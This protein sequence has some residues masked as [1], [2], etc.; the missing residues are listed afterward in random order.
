MLVAVVMLFVVGAMAAL[1]ID[2][3]TIYTARSEAQLAADGAALAGART[4]ANSGM[5]SKPTDALLT[6]NAEILASTVAT[7]VARSNT[8]GGRLLAAGEVIVTFPNAGSPGFGTNPQVT[9]AVKETNV[10]TFFARIWGRTQ[11]TVGTSATAEAYNPS[12]ANALGVANPPPVAPVCVK[13]WLLPNLDPTTGGT[14]TIFTPATGAITNTGLLGYNTLAVASR[15]HLSCGAPGTA[16]ITDCALPL[17][18]P[19]AWQYYPGD[20]GPASFPPPT[21]ALPTCVPALTFPYEESIAGCIQRPI[22][23]NSQVSIDT[24]VYNARRTQTARAVNCLTHSAANAGDQVDTAAAPSP[25][26]QFLAG[27]DNPIAGL[28]GSDV[29]VSDS[30][31]TVPVFDVGPGPAFAVPANPVTI[32]GFVQLFLN[33]DGLATQ[34]FGPNRG[35]VNTTVINMA[36]CGTGFTGTPILGNGA[37]PVAVRLISP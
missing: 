23:C 24:P 8:V 20:P 25:P 31:V 11:V 2:V 13:P 22:A 14:T 34:P 21:Q 18:A 16:K 15:L 37:S 1:S 6:S 3:V 35:Y 29:T 32:V 5:T 19:Q 33:P 27:N 12:G 36:G 30:L 9:V 28:A 17:P 7:Q 10:P 4:L 26:F